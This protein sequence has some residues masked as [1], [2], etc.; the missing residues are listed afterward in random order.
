MIGILRYP[1][2]GN[3]VEY[4]LHSLKALEFIES[5][6]TYCTVSFFITWACYLGTTWLA[7]HVRFLGCNGCCAWRALGMAKTVTRVP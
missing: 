7:T 1:G 5:E 3:S 4:G 2:K 6:F